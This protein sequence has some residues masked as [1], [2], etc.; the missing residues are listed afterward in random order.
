MNNEIL[1]IIIKLLITILSVLITSV[2]IPWI[3]TKVGST[4][5]ND[6][7]SLVE[8]CVEAANQLFTP[9]ECA[10]KKIYVLEITSNYCEEH[11]VNISPEELNAIIE[12]FVKAVKG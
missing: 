12:G 5:Y 2:I 8:K 1:N 3:K 4:K 6:F 11:G 10:E 7:L 9:E